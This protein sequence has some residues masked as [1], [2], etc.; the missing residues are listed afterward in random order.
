M[1]VIK[2]GQYSFGKCGLPTGLYD[3][4]GAALLTGDVVAIGNLHNWNENCF[5]DFKGLCVVVADTDYPGQSDGS[6]FVMGLKSEHHSF[7][8]GDPTNSGNPD[9]DYQFSSVIQ[10]HESWV[11][12]KIK[13]WDDVVHMEKNGG[14][15]CY[16]EAMQ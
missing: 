11:L 3:T 7:L 15:T 13:G 14:I 4:C 1:K 6:C 5:F 12:Q 8:D 2:S 10:N 16:E 9:A